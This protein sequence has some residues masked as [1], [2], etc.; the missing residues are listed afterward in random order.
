M[1]TNLR[2]FGANELLCLREL[3]EDV[4]SLEKGDGDEEERGRENEERILLKGEANCAF[5]I[6]GYVK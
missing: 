3:R 2:S 1:P 4:M 5:G 6:D